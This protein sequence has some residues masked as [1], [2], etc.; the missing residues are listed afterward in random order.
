MNSDLVVNLFPIELS[1]KELTAY[2]GPASPDRSLNAKK[3]V[4][5]DDET[6]VTVL[7]D[8]SYFEGSEEIRVSRD[9]ISAVKRI[10]GKHLRENLSKKGLI[11]GSDFVGGVK[12]LQEMSSSRHSDV[13]TYKEFSIRIFSPR[14]QYIGP[15]N[16]WC[17]SVSCL[18]LIEITSKPLS[19]YLNHMDVISKVI[20]DGRVKKVLDLN[21]QEKA[22]Q[23]TKVIV[24]KRLG[25][26]IGLPQNFYKPS[27]KYSSQ[28]IEIS[29]FYERYLKGQSIE[30]EFVVYE[31]GFQAIPD[32]QVLQASK[33]SNLLVFGSNQANVNPYNGLKENGPY[34]QVDNTNYKFIFI[35]HEADRDYANK[36]YGFLTKGFK[37][38][39]GL[40]RF[41]G[42]DLKLDKERSITFVSD[43][44]TGEIS[45]K[46]NEIEFEANIQYLAI[47]I[48][49]IQRDDP[50]ELKKSYYYKIKKLLLEKNITSQVVYKYNIEKPAFNYYLPNISIAI[51]AKLGGIPWRLS[52][53]IKNDLII[54]VGAFREDENV[55]LGTTVAFQNDG[56]FISFNAQKATTPQ[57]LGEYFHQIISDIS[58]DQ[59]NIKR[60]VIH[61][62]KTMSR[63]EELAITDAL[64][65]LGLK[66]PYIVVNIVEDRDGT[67][68]P[69]DMEYGGKM[70]MSGICVALRRGTYLLC[71][72]TRYFSQ[73][74]QK[75]DDFPFPV[76]INISK[77]SI[78]DISDEEIQ[79]LIDQVYQFSRMY[80]VSI[81]Q[82]GK[83][84]TVEYSEKIAKMSAA[85]LGEQLPITQTANRTLWF[86]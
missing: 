6:E 33:N 26:I 73:T 64:E 35:F 40:F 57:E 13:K 15:R 78:K 55:Y 68:I 5:K 24:S 19:S 22:S 25:A 56:S 34:K 14:D 18:G 51:L 60:I 29:D 42:L 76:H 81:K 46:L 82:K 7:W 47:Y 79:E 8:V 67:I 74:G 23:H 31:S 77:S 4:F 52:R 12:V 21:D 37:G 54:G 83:P 49:Q 28:F 43:D 86:L 59:K 58:K 80:W 3:A 53:P 72:N 71:N 69:F 48:S 9:R 63:K 2:I 66:I 27:N 70:P 62:Y 20:V 16:L 84:V 45:Q 32:G 38:Y 61:F 85:L 44:P 65:K 30:E 41:V 11:I 17:L 39:P 10:L 36:L 75:I 50:D 1:N